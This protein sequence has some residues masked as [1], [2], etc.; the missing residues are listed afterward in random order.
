LNTS[1][2]VPAPCR[3]SRQ[4]TDPARRHPRKNTEENP[5]G[6]EN[7]SLLFLNQEEKGEEK[8]VSRRQVRTSF[9]SA[10]TNGP[11]ALTLGLGNLETG[12]EP[13]EGLVA[14]FWAGPTLTKVGR[15]DAER[16]RSWG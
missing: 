6:E 11:Y 5:S 16:Q 12:E 2:A 9:R 7:A 4:I 15:G 13:G 3:I 1:A 14:P 8:P 10:A